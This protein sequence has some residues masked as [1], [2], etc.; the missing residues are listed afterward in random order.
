M[1]AYIWF[2]KHAFGSL[3]GTACSVKSLSNEQSIIVEI[4]TD[5]TFASSAP[6]C[7]NGANGIPEQSDTIPVVVKRPF[8]KYSRTSE[9]GAKLTS[10]GRPS[11]ALDV[12]SIVL[13]E[14]ASMPFGS[15]KPRGCVINQ[16]F[17]TDQLDSPRGG[18]NS[19]DHN[20]VRGP[21]LVASRLT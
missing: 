20:F 14:R 4:Q 7:K 17:R 1:D 3:P 16:A 13:D 15:R 6:Q 5:S 12:A 18:A 2:G 21:D 8:T 19:T 11:H 10:V 9:L